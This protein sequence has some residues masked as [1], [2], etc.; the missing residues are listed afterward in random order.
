MMK[1]GVMMSSEENGLRKFERKKKFG[2]TY[3]VRLQSDVYA[4]RHRTVRKQEHICFHQFDLSSGI[5]LIKNIISSIF[6]RV[7]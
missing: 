7:N 5:R 3:Y 6:L 1:Q 4:F 2:P